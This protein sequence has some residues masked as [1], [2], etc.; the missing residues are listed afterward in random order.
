MYIP[1]HRNYIVHIK[2][3][4]ITYKS[5]FISVVLDIGNPGSVKETECNT[6]LKGG[7]L[8]RVSILVYALANKTF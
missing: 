2:T 5:D 1:G 8:S 6:P 3:V 7:L 4:S